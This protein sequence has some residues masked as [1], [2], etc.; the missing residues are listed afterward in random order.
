MSST[1]AVSDIAV[2]LRDRAGHIGTRKD[3]FALTRLSELPG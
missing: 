3:L 1:F 2:T